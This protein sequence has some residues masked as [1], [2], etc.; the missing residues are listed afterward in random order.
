M[1]FAFVRTNRHH[2]ILAD[3]IDPVQPLATAGGSDPSDDARDASRRVGDV[4]AGR[5]TRE[6]AQ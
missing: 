4:E 3:D 6:L 5:S 1:Q 2:T